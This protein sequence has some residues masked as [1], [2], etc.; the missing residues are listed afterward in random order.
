MSDIFQL[1]MDE[2]LTVFNKFKMQ[3]SDEILNIAKKLSETFANGGKLLLCGNGG[4]AA[5]AQHLAAEF[6]SSFAVGLN[7]RSLPAIALT[8]DSSIITAISN[9]FSFD[10]SFARQ[11][12]GLGNSGDALFVISTSGESKNCLKAVEAAKNL[13][14]CILSLTRENSSL[15]HLA[16]FSMGV[17][18]R[19]TQHIQEC[20]ILAY[21]V[22]AELVEQDILRGNV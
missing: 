19:N 12:E 17:P 10:L 22:I 4:S 6:M 15:Y 1:R 7:R 18:S 13:G 9:D 14:M 3:C 16:D 21:H 8:T 2:F 5:D 11:I 20:H